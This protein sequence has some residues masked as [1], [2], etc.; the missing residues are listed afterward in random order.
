MMG[1]G[2]RQK[3]GQKWVG[4]FFEGAFR[5]CEM[6]VFFTYLKKNHLKRLV[7]QNMYLSLSAK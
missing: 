5:A 7:F 3:V 2:G 4:C 1:W 6:W